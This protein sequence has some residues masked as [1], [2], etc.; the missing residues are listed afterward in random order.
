MSYAEVTVYQDGTLEQK[1]TFTDDALMDAFI[2]SVRQDA[3]SYGYPT[4]VYIMRHDHSDED[5]GEDTCWCC[6]ASPAG[7]W[8]MEE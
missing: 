6:Y 4:E 3:R 1:E 7:A 2:C 5:P 8:N